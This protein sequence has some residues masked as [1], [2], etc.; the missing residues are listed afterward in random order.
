MAHKFWRNADPLGQRV[1]FGDDKWRTIVGIVGDV[2]HD[3]LD[4]PAAPEMYVPYGQAPNVEARPTIVVR[5]SVDAWRLAGP[6]RRVIASIDP[7]VPVDQ[8]TTMRELVSNSAG[9]P[10]FRTAVILTFSLL[11]LCVASLG[12]YGVI[13]YL[14]TQ[15]MQEFG[16]R[17]SLGATRGDVMRLVFGQAFQMV[18]IGIALGL[19]GTAL[20]SRAVVTLLYAVAPFDTTTLASVTA[21]LTVVAIVA[22]YFPARKAGNSEPMQALSTIS[23]FSN[24]SSLAS[25]DKTRST[26]RI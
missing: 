1:R 22:V 26:K 4:V 19:A 25:R 16:V 12:L 2:H 7:D 14:V 13:N 17:M 6:L 24:W 8:I 18:G 20:L 21:L 9:Q 5:T 11:A 15:R 23:F 3:G 10:R